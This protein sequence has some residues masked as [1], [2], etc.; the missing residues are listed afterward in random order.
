MLCVYLP[1]VL[2]LILELGD[3]APDCIGALDT[4]EGTI[5]IRPAL[6]LGNIAGEC[7]G[8]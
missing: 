2:R 8:G 7:A 6:G 1:G 3:G 5:P 4:G